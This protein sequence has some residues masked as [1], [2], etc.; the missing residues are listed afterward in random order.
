MSKSYIPEDTCVVCTSMTVASPLKLVHIHGGRTYYSDNKKALLNYADKKISESFVCKNAQKFWGGLGSML[1][2]VAAGILIG[3]LIVGTGG[4]ALLV[5]GAIAGVTAVA[6]TGALIAGKVIAKNDCDVI[7]VTNWKLYHKTVYIDERNALLQSSILSCS[8]GGI[9]SI[10][11]DPIKAQRYASTYADNNNDE[12][13]THNTWQAIE[14]L[15]SG[16]TTLGS[17]YAAAIGLGLGT[18][19]YAKNEPDGLKKQYDML[20]GKPVKK[21][22]FAD[23]VNSQLEQEYVNQGVGATV[24]GIETTAEILNEHVI[25]VNQALNGE[26]QRLGSQASAMEAESAALA[27]RGLNQE[28]ADVAARAASTRLAQD[29]ASRSYRMPWTPAAFKGPAI[30]YAKGLGIGLGAAV[31]NFFLE[32]WSNSEENED[33]NN[34]LNQY[35]F[36]SNENASRKQGINIVALRG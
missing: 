31:V 12:I 36:I 14:G 15:I 8:K 30:K 9:V 5:L 33:F 3:A 28:A 34:V 26:I 17:P 25:P 24:G 27:A 4:T 19:F 13:D 29:I 11:P 2:G 1:L 7:Q 22:T 6:G 23:D 35:R 10:V 18:Y 20:E 21:Q 16:I 32:Q